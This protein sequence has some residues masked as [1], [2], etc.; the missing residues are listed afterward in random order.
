MTNPAYE[1]IGCPHH[2]GRNVAHGPCQAYIK[3][4]GRICGYTLPG[5][6]APRPALRLVKEEEVEVQDSVSTLPI[7]SEAT[8]TTPEVTMTLGDVAVFEGT[9][10]EFNEWADQVGQTDK[11][12]PGPKRRPDYG[13]IDRNTGEMVQMTLLG[14]EWDQYQVESLRLAISGGAKFIK[15]LFDQLVS[16]ELSPGAI[17]EVVARGIVKEHAPIYRKDGHEGK[18]VI[19]L[20]VVRSIKVLGHMSNGKTEA[21]QNV[22]G[23]PKILEEPEPSSHEDSGLEDDYTRGLEGPEPG[24]GYDGE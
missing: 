6:P 21:A 3:S 18:T 9:S 14:A 23:G 10:E 4:E 5:T 22:D 8:G 19:L 11:D 7:E 12:A 24:T 13:V 20:E 17:V 2:P 15:S 1:F 16:G